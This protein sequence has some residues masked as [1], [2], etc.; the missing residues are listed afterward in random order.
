MRKNKKL[1]HQQRQILDQRLQSQTWSPR[2]KTGWLKS[3]R[4]ALGLST[5]QLAELMK[6][7]PN[8]VSQLETNE[9]KHT[10]TLKNLSKA[11]EAMDCELIYWIQPKS[12]RSS[13]D[14]ILDQKALFLAQKIAKGVAF[15]VTRRA[16][17]RKP[18]YRKSNQNSRSRIET[19]SRSSLI[20]AFASGK[21][22]KMIFK[23]HYPSN[24]SLDSIIGW[25]LF[26]PS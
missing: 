20:A 13:F 22:Q 6:V 23:P 8:S 16:K 7:S 21:K 26:T 19:R 15:H 14:E 18:N 1:Q 10:A 12:P 9:I 11:A 24:S 2:P 25:F 3:I 4:N 17:S 5:R